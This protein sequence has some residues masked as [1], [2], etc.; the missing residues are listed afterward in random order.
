M[1]SYIRSRKK[2]YRDAPSIMDPNVK[3]PINKSEIRH[4]LEER[5]GETENGMELAALV[6][7]WCRITEKDI[8]EEQ[9][10][11]E[12]QTSS[13]IKEVLINI[14]MFVSGTLI[15]VAFLILLTRL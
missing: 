10:P 2:H 12:V 1:E 14:L 15:G 4:D 8:W 13:V 11:L 5:I 3:C 7:A 6:Q 9:V